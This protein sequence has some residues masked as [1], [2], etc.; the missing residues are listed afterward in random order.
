MDIINAT[1]RFRHPL[2]KLFNAWASPDEGMEALLEILVEE[3]VHDWVG[4]D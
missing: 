3:T 2:D 1:Y 4:T